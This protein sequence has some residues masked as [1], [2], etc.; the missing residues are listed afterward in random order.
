MKR[1]LSILLALALLIPAA[2]NAGGLVG[3]GKM[4]VMTANGKTLNVRST[5]RVEDNIIGHLKY[6]AE[7][8]VVEFLNGWTEIKWGDTTAYVQSRYLQWYKPGPKPQPQPTEDP[9]QEERAKERRELDSEVSIEPVTLQAYATRPTGRVNL[10]QAPSKLG[11]RLETIPDGATLEAFAETNNWYHATDPDTGVSGY[12]YKERVTVI[13]PAEPVEP[14]PVETTA[15][16]GRLSVNGVFD[17]QCKVPEGYRLQVISSQSTRLIASLV[18]DDPAKPQMLL[19]VAYDEMY[20]GTDRMN[21]LSEE[22]IAELKKSFTD[23]NEIEF[24]E[25]ETGKGTKLLVAREAGEDEDFVSFVS[26]YKGYTVE[27]MLTPNPAAATQT[28]T[29]EE[30]GKCVDFL[31]NLEFIPA[32]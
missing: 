8:R 6:G 31:T 11:K 30:I 22:E 16:V 26:V 3:P 32:A 25:M 21:D 2:V 27:F 28:L 10:R 14:E 12:I 4:F 5:P 18:S 24:S 9:N 23:V 1:I 7:V 29:D 15:N 17:L 19:T 13:P 20:S